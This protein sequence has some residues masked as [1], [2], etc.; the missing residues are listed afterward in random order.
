MSG[1]HKN[2]SLILQIISSVIRTLLV[3]EAT[4]WWWQKIKS[5]YATTNTNPY[6]YATKNLN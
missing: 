1:D 4:P 6:I 2:N 3:G 5:F